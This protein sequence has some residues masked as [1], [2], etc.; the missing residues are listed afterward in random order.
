MSKAWIVILAV[1]ALTG[2]APAFWYVGP[3]LGPIQI[4]HRDGAPHTDRQGRPVAQYDS[5]RSFLPIGVYHA[6]TGTHHGRA[7]DFA[8][9]KQAGFNTVHGWEGQTLTTLVE[10]AARN[11]LQLIYHNPTDADIM[12]QRGNTSIL[13]WYLDEEPTL[14]KWDPD[15]TDRFAT[16]KQRRDRIHAM[17]PGRAVPVCTITN[18]LYS[19]LVG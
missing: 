4:V 10:A 7:Y 14:R 12:A 13:A 18:C 15:W 6:L 8:T 17:D 2:C 3:E 16:F 11:G 1:A 19:P 9:L 5:A